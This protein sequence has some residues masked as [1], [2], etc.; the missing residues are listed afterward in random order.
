MA[1]VKT[2]A[3]PA[4]IVQL[5]GTTKTGRVLDW[6]AQRPINVHQL[7]ATHFAVQP[8]DANRHEVGEIVFWPQNAVVVVKR[9]VMPP[10]FRLDEFEIRF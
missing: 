8:L 10:V 1:E 5:S 9:H 2:Y 7:S 6:S 3:F 4:D